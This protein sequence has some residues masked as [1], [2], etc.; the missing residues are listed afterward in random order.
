MAWTPITG[1]F[2]QYSE[3][4]VDANGFYL[5]FYASGT[6]TPI[7]M[8]TDS[9]GATLLDK[10]QLDSDGMPVNGSGGSLIPYIDQKYKLVIYRNSTD[11]DANTFAS[12]YKEIDAIDPVITS[13]PPSVESYATVALAK[14]ATF[15]LGQSVETL[16][17]TA[18]G[19]GGGADYLVSDS[20][21]ADGYNDHAIDGGIKVLALRVGL[22]VSPL[23]SGVTFDGTTDD[24][25]ALVACHAYAVSK[26]YSVWYPYG[27]TAK[28]SPTF[29][30]SDES[31]GNVGTAIQVCFPIIDNLKIDF[32][33]CT[34]RL[35]DNVSSNAT[36]VPIRMFFSNGHQYDVELK[37]GYLDMN[38]ENNKI[39]G[40]NF[41]QFHFGFS[42]TNGGVSAGGTNIRLLGMRFINTAGVTCVAGGQTNTPGLPLGSNWT[43][44]GCEFRDNGLDSSDHSSLYAWFT[45][46]TI[47]GNVFSN[48]S[49]IDLL[50]HVGG[51]VACELHGDNLKFQGNI[52]NNYYQGI[53]VASNATGVRTEGFTISGNIARVSKTFVDFY[54]RNIGSAGAT[55]LETFLYNTVITGNNITLTDEANPDETVR[56]VFTVGCP[57]GVRGVKIAN[58]TVNVVGTA[59]DTVMLRVTSPAN[60]YEAHDQI[61]LIDNQCT[62]G[63][64]A[65]VTVYWDGDSDI[66][67]MTIEKNDFG[68]Y[69][70]GAVIPSVDTYLFGVGGGQINSLSVDYL[71][72]NVANIQVDGAHGTRAIVNGKANLSLTPSLSGVTQGDGTLLSSVFLD[73]NA[74][75]VNMTA[76]F[77]MG[78]TSSVFGNVSVGL[79]GYMTTNAASVATATAIT[80]TNFH[81][82]IG[83][84]DATGSHFNLF[85]STGPVT[86]TN[87][88]TFGTGDIIKLTGQFYTHSVT[89]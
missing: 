43:I 3:D 40:N 75:V 59:Y 16:G 20:V 25:P 42:G 88:I 47:S 65:G 48:S 18:S 58:N 26:G 52:I 71:S 31:T 72:T 66:P 37:N 34:L 85:D 13:I 19:D 27:R 24:T 54:S 57:R 11:A 1:T 33:D 89:L 70:A 86:A 84:N 74:G 76:T 23:Q 77:T 51:L 29:G 53:W 32:N 80:G 15:T 60:V 61:E 21:T 73:T 82:L 87:P 8:A 64:V 17:Y 36:P 5:K 56:G 68:F 83:N 7:S 41:T 55:V 12:A 10:C 14:A 79:P 22:A 38:G 4:N 67:R 44:E 62:G 81:S 49:P 30:T 35:A 2:I 6:T 28:V 39:N 50:N 45:D 78:A 46:S 69:V 63:L 9:T